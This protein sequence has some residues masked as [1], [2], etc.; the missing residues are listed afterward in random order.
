MRCPWTHDNTQTHTHRRRSR[1]R[2]PWT[3]LIA[4]VGAARL[5]LLVPYLP[6][7]LII[8]LNH[9]PFTISQLHPHTVH[10][11]LKDTYGILKQFPNIRHANTTGAGQ[12]VTVRSRLST[13]HIVARA[14]FYLAPKSREKIIIWAS[15]AHAN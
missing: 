1:L 15:F 14:L 11:I 3:S 10:K 8:C 4:T 13:V 12:S 5:V 7:T 6:R 9:F 2:S